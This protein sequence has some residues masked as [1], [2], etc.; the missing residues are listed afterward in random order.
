MVS[1]ASASALGDASASALGDASASALGDASVSGR[2]DASA[3]APAPA[4]ADGSRS[5]APRNRLS[6]F[7]WA[8]LGYEVLVVAW[9]A[10]V[11]ATGS[12]AGCGR[13]WPTCNGDILPRAARVETLIELSHRLSSGGALIG[14]VVLLVWA[15]RVYPR[16][17]RVRSGAGVT[18]LLMVAEA[19]IGAGLVLFELVAHD[20]SM[21]RALSIS[22]HL[23]NTFLLLASTATTAWWASGGRPLRLR[24][25]RGAAS[26]VTIVFGILLAAML[27]VGASGAVTAL[28]DTLFPTPSLAAGIAQDFAPGSHLFVRLRA[29]HP[30]LAMTTAGAIV[31]AMG[32]VRSLRPARA[33]RILSRV[34]ASLAVAQVAAGIADVLARAPVAMQLV[35]L[36]L[37]D[38]VW[39]SLVLTGAAA[40]AEPEVAPL[41]RSTDTTAAP[42]SGIL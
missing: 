18:M 12:G 7:A 40:L 34:A 17:H 10:Y 8:L 2:G 21:K 42:L 16:G 26:A 29:I 23:I 20:A 32:L 9:G 28:G 14:T 4:S 24:D 37:A 3:Q 25:P 5:T 35:H 6:R 38:L 11:R 36:A 33:V 27:V 30:M 22:L 13:H 41:A 15:L 1:H 39:I 19:L 31:V